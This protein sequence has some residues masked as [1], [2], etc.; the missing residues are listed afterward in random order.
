MSFF[1]MFRHS[2]TKPNYAAMNI[3]IEY[4][5]QRIRK[6]EVRA[7][8]P[9]PV[10]TISRE[11]GCFATEI[12]QK[13]TER[14]SPLSPSPWNYITKEIL[15]ESAK[16]LEVPEREIADVFGAKEKGFLADL[17][18]SFSG[19]KYK[20]DGLI[21][22][23]I[24]SVVRKYAEQGN[25]IIVGRAGYCIA[26]DIEQALH[27]RIIAPFDYRAAAIQKRFRLDRKQAEQKVRETDENRKRFMSFFKE[28]RC[29]SEAFDLILN[30]SRMTAD[31]MATAIMALAGERGFV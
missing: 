21:I 2:I 15:E 27:A 3:L 11:Y 22:K 4:M 14:I 19:K 28:Y 16:E 7:Y 30:R 18:V 17:I 9:G 23:T 6:Q 12:A 8:R 29:D 26:K 31:E 1:T 10:I 13:L 20:S 5:N 24:S 25:I